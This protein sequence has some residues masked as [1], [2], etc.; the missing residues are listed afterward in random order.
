MDCGLT[1]PGVSNRPMLTDVAWKPRPFPR[2]SHANA[3]ALAGAPAFSQG[4][5]ENVL[6]N[7]LK[8]V[9]YIYKGNAIQN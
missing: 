1:R 8:S 5:V 4:K 6:L 9:N 2:I 3:Q 7:W